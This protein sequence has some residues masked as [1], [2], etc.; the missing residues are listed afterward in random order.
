MA[1]INS[2]RQLKAAIRKMIV[3]ESTSR[4]STI[5]EAIKSVQNLEDQLTELISEIGQLGENVDKV[6]DDYD[7]QSHQAGTIYK[8]FSDCL[9]PYN[10]MHRT[11]AE[12]RKALKRIG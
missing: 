9:K 4:P 7:A 2:K 5:P 6:L 10:E 11:L 12:I 3:Q 8:L 1:T